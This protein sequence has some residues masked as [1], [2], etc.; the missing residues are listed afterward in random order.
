MKINILIVMTTYYIETSNGR[1]EFKSSLDTLDGCYIKK[2]ETIGI[3]PH[4]AIMLKTTLDT[5]YDWYYV[6]IRST[7]TNGYFMYIHLND[8]YYGSPEYKIYMV[9]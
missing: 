3:I 2:D 8:D 9:N 5:L 6:S 4:D 1:I 7:P